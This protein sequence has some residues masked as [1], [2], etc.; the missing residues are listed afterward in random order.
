VR[1]SA[2]IF[3][4]VSSSPQE[5]S[6]D[7]QVDWATKAAQAQGWAIT[8]TW[9]GVSSGKSGTRRLL[10]DLMTELRATP[11]G[12]RP[13]RLMMVRIDR[14]GR[15]TGIEAIAALA[16]LK[17]LGTTV[18]TREDGDVK[19][20]RASDTIL[21]AIR[22][23]V[24]AL[25]NETRS[26]R[27]R[28]GHAR[29]RAAG[30][31]LGANPYGTVMLA[32][33]PVAFEPEAEIVR[34]VFELIAQ[35]WGLERIAGHVRSKAPAKRLNDGSERTMTW[36]QST[37]R[38]LYRSQVVR[39]IVIDEALL[40]RAEAARAD[41]YRF[42]PTGEWLWPLRGAVRC[43]CGHLLMGHASG[44]PPH[45]VRYYRC[46]SHPYEERLEGNRRPGFRADALEAA[47]VDLLRRLAASPKT[48]LR[49]RP[50]ADIAKLRARETALRAQATRLDRRRRRACELAE[51]GAYSSTDLRDR[52]ERIDAE[53]RATATELDSVRAD[54]R[55]HTTDGAAEVRLA[56]SLA[57]LPDRWPSLP[58]EQ[59]QVVAKAVA[60]RLGGLFADV[61][62]PRK[63]LKG[64]PVAG[65]HK[66]KIKNNSR[67][68]LKCSIR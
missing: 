35:G 65:T 68:S 22:T 63:L 2:W 64:E 30:K 1:A 12:E 34:E 16:E 20:E 58:I 24:A 42:R 61:R 55:A 48:M 37:I 14:L 46:R 29:R 36:G 49:S 50:R 13:Q 28:A 31:H 66:V 56:D 17:R 3:A 59:Q 39:A 57:L 33:K 6:L 47:F 18:F 60:A 26:D 21:P 38:S 41:N 10:E 67:C 19:I 25:E 32:G 27:V 7:A 40:R 45:Q 53:R 15:G 5:I 62:S 9:K 4:A 44:T 43:T 8:R 54:V 11:K 23:I 51:D 52:L